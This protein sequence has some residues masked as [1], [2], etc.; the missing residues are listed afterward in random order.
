MVNDLDFTAA[1]VANIAQTDNTR[2]YLKSRPGVLQRACGHAPG[3][4]RAQNTSRRISTE[5]TVLMASRW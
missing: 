5:R 4:C 2:K 3:G 1:K